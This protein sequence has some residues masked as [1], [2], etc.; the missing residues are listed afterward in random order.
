MRYIGSGN[1]F[2]GC[3]RAGDDVLVIRNPNGL[4][5]PA[6]FLAE[7]NKISLIDFEADF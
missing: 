6:H 4:A 1:F 3:A 5:R 7:M 2:H